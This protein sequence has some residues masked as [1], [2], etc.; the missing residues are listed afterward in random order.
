MSL[1]RSHSIE[2]PKTEEPLPS[3]SS[4]EVGFEKTS[5]QDQVTGDSE[6]NN[7]SIKPEDVE[8]RTTEAQP[9]PH[10]RKDLPTWKWIL[11]IV[12]LG[13]GA[14]LYGIAFPMLWD[15]MFLLYQVSRCPNVFC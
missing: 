8:R 12:C 13:L 14:M 10:P 15:D 2:S 7:E 9:P 5:G 1:P 11:T 6:N 3:D 4:T